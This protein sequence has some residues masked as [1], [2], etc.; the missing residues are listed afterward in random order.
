MPGKRSIRGHKEKV[1][2]S[3]LDTPSAVW[4]Q[5]LTGE[6]ALFSALVL[7]QHCWPDDSKEMSSAPEVVLRVWVSL[8]F[9]SFSFHEEN[10]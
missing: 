3:L 4:R 8:I 2:R 10:F 7:G 5:L 1:S 6:H 9:T